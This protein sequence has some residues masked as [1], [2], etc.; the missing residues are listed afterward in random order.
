M[1]ALLLLSCLTLVLPSLAQAPAKPL[2]LV[3]PPTRKNPYKIEGKMTSTVAAAGFVSAAANA[4][5]A[6]SL[7]ADAM[8]GGKASGKGEGTG[9]TMHSHVTYTIAV[10]PHSKL[11]VALKAARLRDFKVRFISADLGRTEDPGLLPNRIH[12]RDDI[13][14]YDNRTDRIQSIHC[15]LQGVEPMTEEPFALIFTDY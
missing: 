13:A 8:E 9:T 5:G 1:K 4:K 15:D 6:G 14:L 11:M 12:H 10:A 3:D 7:S 2:T